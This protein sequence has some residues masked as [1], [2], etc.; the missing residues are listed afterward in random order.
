MGLKYYGFGRYGK[1]GK[2]THRVI[3]DKLTDVSKSAQ[4]EPAARE[5]IRTIAAAGSSG[6]NI[7]PRQ[8]E[9]LKTHFLI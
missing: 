6:S 5:A 8:K 1:D 2:V 3:H 4:Q 9:K 7:T